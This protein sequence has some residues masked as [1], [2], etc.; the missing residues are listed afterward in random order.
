MMQYAIIGLGVFGKSV[1]TQLQ[2]LKNDVTG[3]DIDSKQV[4][5]VQGLISHA[6]I[7]DAT[8]V[9]I[10]E[11]LNIRQYAGVLVSIGD[12]F[13]A[14]LLCVMNLLNAGV[15][16]KR[17]WVKAKNDTH[18]TILKRLG[19]EHIV[20]PEYDMGIRVGQAMNNPLV[21]QYMPLVD[22]WFIAKILINGALVGKTIGYITEKF[23]DIQILAVKREHE[24]Q[25]TL[26]P[27]YTFQADDRLVV[28]G[29]INSLRALAAYGIVN[30][31]ER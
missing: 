11:D 30:E 28:M 18:Y 31:H 20:R 29:Q 14:S 25:R 26:Q 7:A 4:E 27:D 9:D 8:D 5:A 24:L 3:I 22:N 1:A 12:N 16:T 23:K 15:E 10:L 6:V 2:L 21:L 17:I 19:V 13:E